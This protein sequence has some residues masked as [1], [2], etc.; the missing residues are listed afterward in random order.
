M[1]TLK[2]SSILLVRFK[3][4]ILIFFCI[5]S[6]VQAQGTFILQTFNSADISIQDELAEP[7]YPNPKLVLRRALIVPGWGQVANK[8]VWKVPLVYGLLG[9]L[10]YYSVYLTKKYHDYRAAYYNS[11]SANT[12]LRFGPTP[13]YLEG[14]NQSG[15]QSNRN[16]LRNRRD[17]IYV[18]IGLAYVLQVIEAYVFAHLRSFDVSD[19]LSMSTSIKPDL[20]ASQT[21]VFVPSLSLTISLQKK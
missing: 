1:K 19:D 16:F 10:T 2:E 12:D 8:Q 11:F 5:V 6:A 18:T 20:L 21:S 14:A 17:F 3:S 15:L 7:K 9:G 13:A 4:T